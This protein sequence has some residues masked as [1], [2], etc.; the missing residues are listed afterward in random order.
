MADNPV[1]YWRMNEPSGFPLDLTGH[2]P[3]L[4]A[5]GGAPTYGVAS[6]TGRGIKF[7]AGNFQ[8]DHN[9]YMDL[10]DVFSIE[11]LIKI[12]AVPTG[13]DSWGILSSG[14]QG[15][16]LRIETTTGQLRLIRSGILALC[17]S[18]I[19]LSLGVWH[20]VC[21]TKTGAAIKLYIDSVDVT[22]AITN[23]T[24]VNTGSHLQLGS[25]HEGGEPSS[26]YQCE[27]ALF[28]TVLSPTRV[29]ARWNFLTLTSPKWVPL[30]K[31]VSV[32]ATPKWVPVHDL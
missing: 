16:Y 3:M 27:T 6:P 1:G 12:D 15:Y 29:Q 14:G 26:A 21:A 23:S 4:Y 7:N 8:A 17:A 22:G 11:A 20:H 10:G 32:P 31:A 2:L 19:S 18:T 25:D 13:V 24:V 28:G 5:Q 9:A 30:G